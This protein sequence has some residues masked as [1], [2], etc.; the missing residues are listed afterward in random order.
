M[1]WVMSAVGVVLFLG[2]MVVV[3]M[4]IVK[5]PGYRRIFAARHF[6]EF[7]GLVAAAG[8]AG[9]TLMNEPPIE[10]ANEDGRLVVSSAGLVFVYSVDEEAGEYVHRLSVSIAGKYTPHA[11]GGT[12]TVFAAQVLGLDPTK[13]KVGISPNRVHH[14]EFLLQ[15]AEQAEFERRTPTVPKEEQVSVIHKECG[16]LRDRL[17]WAKIEAEQIG[18]D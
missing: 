16:E 1:V 12:F 2:M 14:A 7:G 5:G 15:R 10:P 9:C 17:D 18:Q 13:G 3:L 6:V 11:L 4:M 8:K